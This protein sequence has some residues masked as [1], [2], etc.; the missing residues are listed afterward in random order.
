MSRSHFR[1]NKRLALYFGHEA[2][3]E[4]VSGPEICRAG[5]LPPYTLARRISQGR[6]PMPDLHKTGLRAW[7][8]D[9]IRAHDPQLAARIMEA[10]GC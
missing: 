2:E 10:R 6:F 9:A 4:F 7:R 8:Q 3:E 1:M 5:D